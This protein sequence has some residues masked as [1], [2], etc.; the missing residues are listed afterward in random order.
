MDASDFTSDTLIRWVAKADRW[1]GR[2]LASE[3]FQKAAQAHIQAGQ[4]WQRAAHAY[5]SG[6]EANAK[7]MYKQA[8]DA[9]AKA[10]N[11]SAEAEMI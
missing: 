1:S 7:V 4:L 9:S 3:R 6:D 11:L 5:A 8:H 2:D 10:K